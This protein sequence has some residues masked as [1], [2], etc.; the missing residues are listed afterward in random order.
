MLARTW[1]G[2][3]ESLLPPHGVWM[4]ID[5]PD[6]KVVPEQVYWLTLTEKRD[7]GKAT[8]SC[9]YS[10]ENSYVDGGLLRPAGHVFGQYDLCFRILSRC[11]PVPLLRRATEE[12][13]KA[14]PESAEM[15]VEWG[16]AQGER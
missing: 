16:T 11:A 9:G 1:L 5:L 2:M 6:T 14:L 8:M 15:A 3:E 10:R 12:E 7:A 13:V 4:P